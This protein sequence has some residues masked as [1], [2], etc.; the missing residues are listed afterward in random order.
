MGNREQLRFVLGIG[1][2]SQD[3]GLCIRQLVRGERG[4]NQR[5]LPERVTHPYPIPCGRVMD[6]EPVRDRNRRTLE[7]LS[8]PLERRVVLGGK[9]H[10]LVLVGVQLNTERRDLFDK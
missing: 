10:D 4:M 8:K 1:P 3:P 2:T 6:I 7:A 5:Q 9:T